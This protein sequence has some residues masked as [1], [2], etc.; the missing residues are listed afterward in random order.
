[1]KRRTEVQWREL[2]AEHESRG[3]TAA[4]FC[5]ERGLCSSHFSTRRK[6]LLVKEADVSTASTPSF[7]P[8]VVSGR[9]TTMM[10]ELHWGNAYQLRVPTSVSP[11]WLAT[12]IHQLAD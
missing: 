10:I 1:M 2:F 5:R 9:A 7:I 6:Q 11:D 12:F 8:V 3:L 4:A